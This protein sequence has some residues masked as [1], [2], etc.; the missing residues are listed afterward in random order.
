[1]SAIGTETEKKKTETKFIEKHF[2][3]SNS[4]NFLVSVPNYGTYCASGLKNL[5]NANEIVSLHFTFDKKANQFFNSERS[6]IKSYRL[7]CQD[8]SSFI[9]YEIEIF[10][11]KYRLFIN[12]KK[13]SEEKIVLFENM[14]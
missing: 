7:T 13:K 4:N 12:L 10:D 3:F 1:M 11:S 5:N 9:I 8:F 2:F 14:N 6:P